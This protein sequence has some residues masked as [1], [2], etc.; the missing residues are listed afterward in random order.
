MER[1]ATFFTPACSARSIILESAVKSAPT[2]SLEVIRKLFF[3]MLL[4]RKIKFQGRGNPD[5]IIRYVINPFWFRLINFSGKR[6]SINTL[7]SFQRTSG[8]IFKITVH[9]V[10]GPHITTA[11]IVVVSVAIPLTHELNKPSVTNMQVILD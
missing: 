11:N 10:R 2:L 8:R 3:D 9:P 5:R 4:Y 1:R 6:E 7:I